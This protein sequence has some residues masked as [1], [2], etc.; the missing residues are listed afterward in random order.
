MLDQHFHN[1]KSHNMDQIMVLL[2]YLQIKVNN[3]D[4]SKQH[5]HQYHYFLLKSILLSHLSEDI[6]NLA[7]LLQRKFLLQIQNWVMIS[8]NFD[9]MLILMAQKFFYQHQQL[10]VKNL[11][12][13][14]VFHYYQCK[15]EYQNHLLM[16]ISKYYMELVHHL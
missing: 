13:I 10:K 5:L 8:H 16:V 12:M 4:F 3:Q 6:T 2:N 14:E 15:Q 7:N 1:L 9:L 11:H